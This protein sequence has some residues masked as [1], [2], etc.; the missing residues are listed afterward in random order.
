MVK[1][2]Q[3]LCKDL[4]LSPDYT[5]QYL[6]RLKT[7]CY[8][9]VSRDIS[10]YGEPEKQYKQYLIL[11]K[12]YLDQFLSNVSADFSV[13]IPELNN[14]TAIQYA[15]AEG[16]DRFLENHSSLPKETWSLK[17]NFGMTPLHISANKGYV[18]T[19]NVLLENG[20]IPE[21]ANQ[22]GQF[23]IYTALLVPIVFDPDLVERKKIIF[24]SLKS[25]A[26]QSI[27]HQD[28]GG[29]TICI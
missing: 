13:I 23:P 22:N 16:Y 29:D 14:L 5:I 12:S 27:Y 2:Y 24:E 20:A 8:E 18:H 21:V 28:K 26:P 3:D 7:W 4:N 6:E 19:V 11:A 1:N 15:A 17:N 10:F 9:H 25:K